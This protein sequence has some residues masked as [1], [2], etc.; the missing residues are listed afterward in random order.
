[1]SLFKWVWCSGEVDC[2]L[3]LQLPTL[4]SSKVKCLRQCLSEQC[5]N[6]LYMKVLLGFWFHC[7][8]HI[9]CI[10]HFSLLQ[11]E[12]FRK[13]ECPLMQH[14]NYDCDHHQF[15]NLL[16]C[17]RLRASYTASPLSILIYFY[18][19]LNLSILSPISFWSRKQHVAGKCKKRVLP[20][21]THK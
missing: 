3:Q 14:W 15:G 9:V 17:P 7:S 11:K 16:L 18:S 10:Q 20:A 19:I 2:F 13:R 5:Y 21:N 6:L 4:N 8:F 12:V 1:M